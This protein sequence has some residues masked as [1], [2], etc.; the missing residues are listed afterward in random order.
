MKVKNFKWSVARFPPWVREVTY[1]LGTGRII[2]RLTIPSRKGSY[3][4]L[5][6]RS[7]DNPGAP[8][9]F[10]AVQQIQYILTFTVLSNTVFAPLI[11]EHQRI[12]LIQSIRDPVSFQIN[13]SRFAIKMKSMSQAGFQRNAGPF[14]Q[15]LCFSL[16]TRNPW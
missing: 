10:C 1:R 8:T 14:W 7:G 4:F 3:A 13:G 12:R 6:D 15:S 11:A 2:S 16:F 5:L 9:P